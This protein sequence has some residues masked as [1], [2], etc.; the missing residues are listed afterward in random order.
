[1]RAEEVRTANVSAASCVEL[2]EPRAMMEFARAGANRM[3]RPHLRAR[4]VIGFPRAGLTCFA[5]N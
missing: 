1:V 2:L 5:I 4:L 3:K